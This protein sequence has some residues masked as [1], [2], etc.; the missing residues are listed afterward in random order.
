LGRHKKVFGKK[1][2]SSF[3]YAMTFAE[4]CKYDE[5]HTAADDG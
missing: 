5:A 4:K 2:M 1:E 3:Y